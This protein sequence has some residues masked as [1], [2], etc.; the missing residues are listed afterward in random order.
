M[1]Y[2]LEKVYVIDSGDILNKYNEDNKDIYKNA[3]RRVLFNSGINLIN[4]FSL[5]NDIPKVA[6]RVKGNIDK[7]LKGYYYDNDSTIH[8]ILENCSRINPMYS[9]PG[10]TSNATAQGVVVHEYGHYLTSSRFKLFKESLNAIKKR[11]NES[12]ITSYCPDTKE[13]FAE[14]LKLFITNPDLLKLIRP[15]TYKEFCKYW[16]PLDKGTYMEVLSEFVDEIPDRILHRLEILKRKA[17][18]Q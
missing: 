9:F 7:R 8:V 17:G 18:V 12:C 11:I 14:Q 2:E 13:W 15:N 10:F 4:E 5:L 3:F 1:H 16:K 6:V